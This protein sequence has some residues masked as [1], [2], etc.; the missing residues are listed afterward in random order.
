M[1]DNQQID[2]STVNSHS[3]QIN[4]GEI[5]MKCYGYIIKKSIYTIIILLTVALSFNS[6]I[7]LGKELN[8]FNNK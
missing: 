2:F 4:L 1:T 6:L 7:I 8:Y 5:W 3:P